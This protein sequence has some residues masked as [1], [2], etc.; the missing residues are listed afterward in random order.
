MDERMDEWTN[1]WMGGLSDFSKGRS[2]TW[3]FIII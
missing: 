2:E 1:E 3:L